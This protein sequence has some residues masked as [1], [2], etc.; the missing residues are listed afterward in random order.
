MDSKIAIANRIIEVTANRRVRAF[1]IGVLVLAVLAVLQVNNLKRDTPMCELLTNSNLCNNDLQRIQL[2]LSQSGLKEYQLVD[3]HLVVPTAQHSE[4]LQ[5]IAEKNAIPEELRQSSQSAQASINPFLTHRQQLAI[6]RAEKKQQVRD[7]VL[8]LPFVDQAWFEMDKSE[9]HSAFEQAEQSAVVSIRTPTH[10][11]LSDQHVDTVKRMIGGAVAGLGSDNIVV[12]DLSAGRVHHDDLDPSTIQQ[13]HFQRI[14]IEHQRLYESQIREV[15]RDY[16]GIK[17]SVHVD[18]KPAPE[19]NHVASIPDSVPA[20]IQPNRLAP[21]PTAGANSFA[22]IEPGIES[23]PSLNTRATIELTS[24]TADDPSPERL[25]KQVSV[26]IDVPQ[27]LLYDLFGPPPVSSSLATGPGD[28]QARMAS[29]ADAK[30]EQLRSEII[31]KVQPILPPSKNQSESTPISV[32]LIRIPLPES[33]QWFSQVQD[34]AIQNWPSAAVLIIGLMLLS[35]VTRKP[36]SFDQHVNLA[37]ID[38]SKDI[39]SINS[40]TGDEQAST[41]Y[42]EIRLSKLIEKDP[43]AAARVIEAWIRDAA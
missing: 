1:S 3:N 11:L 39:L 38:E 30:F 13:V 28:L 32:N 14:A 26:S 4:Y 22:S 33:T 2:A 5:A 18:V 21:L 34:Y 19:D 35:I 31:Q 43:D 6:D 41:A 17:I 42:P 10:V 9:S 24:H 37:G 25:V 27:K 7:M 8:R 20:R 36:E 23:G 15:L 12:I 16:A 40:S 29:D